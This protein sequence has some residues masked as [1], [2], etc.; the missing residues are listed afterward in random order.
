M[1]AGESLCG[2]AEAGSGSTLVAAQVVGRAYLGIELEEIYSN[3]ARTRT[4]RRA[5]K[6]QPTNLIPPVS[7]YARRAA[8]VKAC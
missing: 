2:G 3:I 4:Q 6:Q 5:A 1:P 7:D 8:C